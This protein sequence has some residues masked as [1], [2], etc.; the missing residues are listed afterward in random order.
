MLARV[1][2]PDRQHHES[3]LLQ[4]CHETFILLD[5]TQWATDWPPRIAWK[6]VSSGC[7]LIFNH[8]IKIL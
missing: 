2:F 4:N 6:T 3:G 8:I 5:Q 1:V 7:S